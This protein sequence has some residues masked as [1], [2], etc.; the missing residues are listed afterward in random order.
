[1][2][3]TIIPK[4]HML[5]ALTRRWAWPRRRARRAAA[6]S[7]LPEVRQ[8]PDAAGA[9]LAGVARELC[10]KASLVLRAHTLVAAALVVTPQHATCAAEACRGTLSICL[11]GARLPQCT[12]AHSWPYSPCSGY[13]ISRGA[14]AAACCRQGPAAFTHGAP[15]H[16]LTPSRQ[17]GLL[18][19]CTGH[20][21]CA[22][23][24]RPGHCQAQRRLALPVPLAK[25]HAAVDSGTGGGGPV[26]VRAARGGAA[27]ALATA[28]VIRPQVVQ[29]QDCG[30]RCSK[31]LS[32][33]CE[34]VNTRR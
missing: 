11:G 26:V 2:M 12:H 15:R 30:N 1:M 23:A 25:P 22:V 3:H 21:A 28:L 7:A 4:W 32:A 16:L 31:P 34:G 17:A 27:A 29:Q 10:I 14:L 18:T 33:A 13:S 24:C 19:Y 8:L 9:R 6:D 20:R 5:A